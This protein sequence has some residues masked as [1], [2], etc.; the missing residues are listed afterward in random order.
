MQL[1]ITSGFLGSGK[2]TLLLIIA[3]HFAA[4]GKKIAIIENE[5]GKTGIDN[6]F[7]KEYD[8]TVKEIFS[9]CI[10]CSLRLDLINS[11]LEIERDYN[12][13]IVI[14]EPSGIAGPKKVVQALVG[15][16]GEISSKVILSVI[17]SKRFQKVE[18]MSIPLISDGISVADIVVINKIDL[19]DEIEYSTLEQKIKT[20]NSKADIF[21]ISALNSINTDRLLEKIDGLIEHNEHNEHDGHGGHDDH[22]DHDDHDGHDG[23]HHHH[24]HE[25]P[26]IISLEREYI[27]DSFRTPEA[28]AN[29]HEFAKLLIESGAT[30]IGNL[31]MIIKSD[32]GGYLYISTTSFDEEPHYKGALPLSFSKIFLTLNAIVYGIT[33]EKLKKYGNNFFNLKGEI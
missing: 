19:T 7:L 8:F 26:A 20:V 3:R 13:D 12:P 10:C 15:Y 16:S 30:L 27:C 32:A 24:D 28:V 9:G 33:E 4:K 2:T 22:D 25:T 21:G 29:L 17:D 5:I 11:L 1:L 14:L 31:K 6:E 18:D 23:H